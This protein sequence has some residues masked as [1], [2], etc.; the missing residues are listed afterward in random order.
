MK[1][2]YE[3]FTRFDI[4]IYTTSSVLGQETTT[5]MFKFNHIKTPIYLIKSPIPFICLHIICIYDYR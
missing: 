3:D 2:I 5:G 1:S 4:N